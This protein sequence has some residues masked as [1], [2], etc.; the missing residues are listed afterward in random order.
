VIINPPTKCIS[1]ITVTNISKSFTHK[2][3]TETS[4]HRHGTKLQMSDVRTALLTSIDSYDKSARSKIPKLSACCILVIPA[5]AFT[6]DYV[7]TGVG[8]SV[9]YH[10]N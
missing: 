4:W 2:M 3:A 6:R 10:D 8:L 5:K 9:C 1:V 7:I